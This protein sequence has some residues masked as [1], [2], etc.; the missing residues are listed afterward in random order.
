MFQL[1]LT[2]STTPDGVTTFYTGIDLT[3]GLVGPQ[4]FAWADQDDTVTLV[5]VLANGV[6]VRPDFLGDT[7]GI[8]FIGLDGWYSNV[9]ADSGGT[10][11]G[12]LSLNV[13]DDWDVPEPNS[14]L[15]VGA[16]LLSVPWL[17]IRY[18]KRHQAEQRRRALA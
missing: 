4:T 12:N 9:Y 16:G 3:T 10:S 2:S 6:S 18:R 11:I 8:P 15:L 1:A 7:S 5:Q 17:R 13:V 14:L